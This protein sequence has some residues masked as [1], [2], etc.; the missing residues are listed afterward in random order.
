MPIIEES[1]EINCAVDKAFVYTTDPS[2]W[3]DWQPFPESQ[4]TSPG[5]VGMGTTAKGTIRLMGVTMKWTGTVTEYEPNGVFGKKVKSG[6]LDVKERITFESRAEGSRV[7]IAYDISLPTVMKPLSPIL[8]NSMRTALAKALRNLKS[9]LE[10][11][12][13]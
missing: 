9:N 4:Q 13:T 7:A 10:T 2:N 5:P 12:S 1:I 11:A 6:P 8:M 3:P